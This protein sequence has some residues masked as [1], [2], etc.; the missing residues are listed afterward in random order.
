MRVCKALLG[1]ILGRTPGRPSKDR[2]ANAILSRLRRH[3]DDAA[4]TARD[5]VDLDAALSI[6]D[7]IERNRA[8]RAHFDR[9]RNRWNTRLKNDK[10]LKKM[11][12][13]A[14]VEVTTDGRLQI[15]YRDPHGKP[16]KLTLNLDHIERLADDPSLALNANNLR[17]T[18][19]AE[20]QWVLEALRKRNRELGEETAA[21][22]VD[23]RLRQREEDGDDTED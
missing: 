13:S 7:P 16:H 12:E 5:P 18:T 9:W 15:P 10:A 2:R 3:W 1:Q 11:L 4:R 22:K 8:V 21:G 23:E 14:G 20:N 17:L 19:P 6:A